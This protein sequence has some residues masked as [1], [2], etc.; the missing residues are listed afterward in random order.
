MFVL[1][2]RRVGLINHVLSDTTKWRQMLTENTRHKTPSVQCPCRDA[3]VPSLMGRLKKYVN[4]TVTWTKT[5]R[6]QQ[7]WHNCHTSPEVPV[8]R[9]DF[10][11]VTEPQISRRPWT[12]HNQPH[13]V[14]CEQVLVMRS[15]RR[16]DW[17]IDERKNFQEEKGEKK[18]C[19]SLPEIQKEA[20]R[21]WWVCLLVC[22]FA[23]LFV[24][25]LFSLF[26]LGC[27]LTSTVQTLMSTCLRG[28]RGNTWTWTHSFNLLA[29]NSL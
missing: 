17:K 26:A 8:M 6:A 23:S 22:L 21:S 14:S 20:Q 24:W 29:L 13:L 10:Y 3:D 27:L 28:K 4:V 5:T 12:H 16:N 15:R 9:V 2:M 7:K 1:K 25:L 11:K 18:G 19:S